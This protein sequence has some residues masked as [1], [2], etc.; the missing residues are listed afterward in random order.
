MNQEA[1]QRAV[2]L[3]DRS[4]NI[5]ITTHVKPDGDA[6]G[7]VAALGEVL[8]GRGKT[9]Q[10]LLLSAMPDWYGFLFDEPVPVLD[11]EVQVQDLIRSRFGPVDLIIIVDT[12]SYSQLPGFRDYLKQ[13]EV[14]ALVFDHHVTSDNLGQVEVTD[15]TAAAAGLIVVEFLQAVGWPLTGRS[16]EALF[17]AISTDTGWFHLRNT[18]SRTFRAVAELIDAGAEPNGVYTKLYQ[19]YSS[20]RFNLMIA[21][22]ETLELKLDGR[23]ASQH[24]SRE[25][26]ERTGAA[27]RDTENLISEC[28]RI[29]SVKV[30]ALFIEQRDGRIRCSMRSRDDLDVSEIAVKYG[31]GGHKLAAGTFLPAPLEHAKQ[32]IHDEV[33]Q[34]LT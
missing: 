31:G 32:L 24:L 20:E 27:Y 21:M 28:Q 25:A 12:N 2:G 30:A 6:C 15:S 8:R 17:V 33:A 29:A 14:P 34:R 19:N 22:L 26:F 9:V 3:I 5:L 23:Y 18:D 16:A 7:C 11:R 4:T 13:C 1:C 10:P